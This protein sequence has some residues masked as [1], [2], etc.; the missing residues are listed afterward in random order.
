MWKDLH[1]QGLNPLW[2]SQMWGCQ[3][4]GLYLM[5]GIWTT[6]SPAKHH[7]PF[8]SFHILGPSGSWVFGEPF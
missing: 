3:A 1:T 5:V 4:I 7:L 2:P 6:L 8:C